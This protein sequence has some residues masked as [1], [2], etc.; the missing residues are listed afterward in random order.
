VDTPIKIYAGR[1]HCPFCGKRKKFPKLV[2]CNDCWDLLLLLQRAAPAVRAA[3]MNE[4]EQR[5]QVLTSQEK[6]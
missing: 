1:S 4:A 3:L 2:G 5:D 6:F